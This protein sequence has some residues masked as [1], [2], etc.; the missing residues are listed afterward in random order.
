MRRILVLSAM[1]V[2]AVPAQAN[3]WEKFYTPSSFAKD[4]LIPASDEPELIPSTGSVED[5]IKAMWERGFAPIGYS[6][7]NTGNSKT[8]DAQKLAKKLRARYFV[9]RTQLTSSYTTNMPWTSPKTTTS[10]TS[11]TVSASGSG[12]YAQGNYSGTATTQ[13]TQT[14]Y[15]PITINRFDKGAIYFAETPKRGIGVFVRKPTDGE[16]RAIDTRRAFFIMA[17]RDGSPAYKADILPGDV[18]IRVNDQPADVENW[19]AALRGLSLSVKIL[20]NGQPRE[21]RVDVPADWRPAE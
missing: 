6:F 10:Y 3:D 19:E 7:F 2:I 12:G 13:S 4:R 11:G 17:V 8:K 21:I 16:A 20:R 14:S 1:L 5:D 9:I 18:I 15:I